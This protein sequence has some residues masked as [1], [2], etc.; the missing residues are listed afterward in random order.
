MLGA[1][2]GTLGGFDGDVRLFSATAVAAFAGGVDGDA[3]D[4]AVG[5]VLG[6]AAVFG[7]AGA[8]LE[9]EGATG[10]AGGT[11]AAGT[12]AGAAGRA[13]GESTSRHTSASASN[14]RSVLRPQMAQSHPTANR[15]CCA[16]MLCAGAISRSPS[17]PM[18]WPART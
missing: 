17:G 1:L 9:A 16:S 11:C 4:D 15:L 6:A 18:E 5:E 13:A 10:A 12:G 8:A 14:V 3:L 7:T 2:G